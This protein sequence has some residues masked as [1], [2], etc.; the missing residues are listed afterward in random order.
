MI[1]S[2]I[3]EVN[4]KIYIYE[5]E[6]LVFDGKYTKDNPYAKEKISAVGYEQ[7]IGSEP[8]KWFR[9]IILE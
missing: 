3:A 6:H 4:E 8:E 7:E 9:S 5:C 2:D 1:V